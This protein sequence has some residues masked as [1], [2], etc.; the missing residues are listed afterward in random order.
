LLSATT[1]A[2]TCSPPELRH[3]RTSARKEH[4]RAGLT[5]GLLSGDPDFK[6]A[7]FSNGEDVHPPQST[8][9][10]RQTVEDKKYEYP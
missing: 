3:L 4:W 7:G 8:T 5:A 6:P 2:E 9:P 10:P 1:N